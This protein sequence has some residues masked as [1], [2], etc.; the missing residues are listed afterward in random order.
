MLRKISDLCLRKFYVG[1]YAVRYEF[2]DMVDIVFGESE[3]WWRPFI[4]FGGV[5][6]YSGVAILLNIRNDAGHGVFYILF[7]RFLLCC[8]FTAFD[9]GCQNNFLMMINE[10]MGARRIS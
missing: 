5:V 9:I 1:D 3:R 10:S 2:H 6:P 8:A 7:F 4:E